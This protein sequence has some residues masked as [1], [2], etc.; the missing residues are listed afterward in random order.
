MSSGYQREQGKGDREGNK[1]CGD[2]RNEEG[3]NEEQGK[4]QREQRRCSDGAVGMLGSSV[5]SH[6]FGMDLWE[7]VQS[8]DQ[9]SGVLLQ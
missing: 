5:T 7:W 6:V 3:K 8:S 9:R 4:E 1:L 2:R